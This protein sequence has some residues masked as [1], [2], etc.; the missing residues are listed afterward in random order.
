MYPEEPFERSALRSYSEAIY[1]SAVRLKR[2]KT[3]EAYAV[4]IKLFRRGSRVLHLGR[5]ERLEG[6]RFLSVESRRSELVVR[7]LEAVRVAGYAL[8]RRGRASAL[9]VDWDGH[10]EVDQSP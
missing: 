3:V 5:G 10:R 6:N 8:L 4:R 7:R 1:R 2:E 9:S